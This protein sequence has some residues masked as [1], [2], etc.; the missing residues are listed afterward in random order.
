MADSNQCHSNNSEHT[1]SYGLFKTSEDEYLPYLEVSVLVSEHQKQ[2]DVYR[3]GMS[4]RV[5]S[6]TFCLNVCTGYFQAIM[7]I[8]LNIRQLREW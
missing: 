7:H 1:L 8:G 2:F 5:K 3:R 4:Q 6:Y